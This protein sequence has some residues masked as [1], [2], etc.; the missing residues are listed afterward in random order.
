MTP[1]DERLAR[2]MLEARTIAMVGASLRPERASFGVARYL[3]DAGYRV[4]PVNPGYVG[5]ELF[6]EAFVSDLNEIEGPVDL[7]NLFRRSEDVPPHVEEALSLP[8]RP[9]TIWMQLGISN[10]EARASAEAQGLQ[11]VENRCLLV[12]HRRLISRRD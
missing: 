10:A 3:V 7:V 9:K 6:D 4:I 12:E 5:Q 8:Q 1:N 2:I 11:V